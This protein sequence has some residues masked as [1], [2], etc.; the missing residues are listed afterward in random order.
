MEHLR[1]CRDFFR[2]LSLS[3]F[4]KLIY[5]HNVRPRLA[6]LNSSQS[7]A[8]EILCDDPPTIRRHKL[9]ETMGWW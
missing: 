3:R 2:R 9:M 5:Q 7:E 4:N 8:R 6:R 1:D